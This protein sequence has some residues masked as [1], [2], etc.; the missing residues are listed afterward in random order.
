MTKFHGCIPPVSSTFDAEGNVDA[1]AAKR[2]ADY[3]IEHGV[4]GLFYLGTGGE[5][6]QMNTAERKAMAEA[7]VAAAAGRVPV[8][9]GVGSPNTRE[10]VE[11]AKHAES[12]GA[13]GIVV[14]NPYYWKVAP[15]N[16]DAYYKAI[17]SAVKLPVIIYNFPDL[18][19]QDLNAEV[20][21]RLVL[22]NDNIVGIKETIDNVGHIRA[23]IRTIKPIRPDFSVF[24]GYDDHLLNTLELGGDGSIT[25]SMNFAPDLSVGIYEAFR[26]GDYQKAVELDKKLVQLP[27]LY[28]IEVPF[29]SVIKYATVRVAGVEMN[30]Y[31]L[32]PVRPL[33]DE[34]K[35]KV[36]A[37]LKAEGLL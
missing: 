19:G 27:A 5:F 29:M 24:A 6:S 28:G 25:A 33:T 11:L 22:A 12:I 37:F 15:A 20:V 1:A 35:A 30:T 9:I 2:L 18:T 17:C 14:I 21:K 32:P 23:M 8:L 7:G 13:D 10:A 16:L 31:A 36:D 34:V 26:K 3:L 4:H